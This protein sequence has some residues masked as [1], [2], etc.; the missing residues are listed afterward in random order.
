MAIV[1]LTFDNEINVS[2]QKGDKIYAVSPG[3]TSV[4]NNNLVGIVDSIPN[5]LEI[6]VDDATGSYNALANDFIMFQKNNSINTTSL[7]GYYANVKLENTSTSKVELF[8]V[9]SEISPSSK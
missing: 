4:D 2:A 3:I 7:K 8:S 9:A 6:N 5:K 1:K